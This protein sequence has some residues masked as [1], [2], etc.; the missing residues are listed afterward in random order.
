M[1]QCVCATITP[2]YG[3]IPFSCPDAQMPSQ[4]LLCFVFSFP[5]FSALS[6]T[7]YFWSHWEPLAVTMTRTKKEGRNKEIE[8]KRQRGQSTT[9]MSDPC[10]FPTRPGSWRLA[11]AQNAVERPQND[12]Q[13]PQNVAKQRA[14]THVETPATAAAGSTPPPRATQSRLPEPHIEPPVGLCAS[15]RSIHE[16]ETLLVG[17]LVCR[18]S[19]ARVYSLCL[20]R[21]FWFLVGGDPDCCCSQLDSTSFLLFFTLASPTTETGQG[22][23]VWPHLRLPMFT[24]CQTLVDAL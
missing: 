17:R 1:C 10:R 6:C 21:G 8:N 23:T 9:E 14:T 22:S 7:F 20:F 2:Y 16:A 24:H 13:S 4:I 12:P 18:G 15:G 19:L 11:S 3:K 5:L